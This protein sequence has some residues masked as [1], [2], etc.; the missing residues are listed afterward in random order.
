MDYEKK[1]KNALEWA[2]Q[3][4]NGETGFIRKEV[5]EVFPEL[6]ESEDERIRKE[7]ISALKY[8]NHKGV[9]DKH[10][11]WLEKQA[12]QKPAWSEEDNIILSRIIADYERSNEEW[13]NAQKSLPHGRKITWLKSLKER[14]KGKAN[15][16]PERLYI[17]LDAFT[18]DGRTFVLDHCVDYPICTEYTR[19]DAFI[20]KACEW[21][22][23]HNDYQR[24]LDN[25]RGVR[26]DMT[27]CIIDFRKAMKEE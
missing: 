18:E 21:L 23:N 15:E 16:A 10:L 11:V 8:A 1:Y 19:T 13:F 2:R 12:E 24:V 22:E 17:A 6:K 9:Y 7:I 5:E 14:M 26:F 20:E 3:I 25:G 27:Q 4:M